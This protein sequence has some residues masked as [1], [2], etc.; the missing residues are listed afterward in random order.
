MIRDKRLSHTLRMRLV[1]AIFVVGAIV[2]SCQLEACHLVFA[3]TVGSVRTCLWCTYRIPRGGGM[4][5]ITVNQWWLSIVHISVHAI[6]T[7]LFLELS[8][9]VEKDEIFDYE[10]N[11]S[12]IN[13]D[14]SL[15]KTY[16]LRVKIWNESWV[17]LR[18]GLNLNLHWLEWLYYLRYV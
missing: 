11:F 4:S 6:K 15:Y 9:Q 5:Y 13:V 2:R 14:C 12:K 7:N 1:E 8:I 18:F 3:N 10:Y 17:L 16:D